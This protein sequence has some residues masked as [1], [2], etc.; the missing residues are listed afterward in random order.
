[1]AEN[2]I[3]QISEIRD[4]SFAADGLINDIKSKIQES[5]VKGLQAEE[6]KKLL[7]LA[8]AAF[9]REDFLTAIQRA[10]DAQLSIV[11]E[12]KGNINI[13][14]F[15]IDYQWPILAAIIILLIGSYFIRRQ[16]ILILISRR[17]ENL[18]KEEATINELIKE[19]QEK[20][21]KEKKIGTTEYHKVMYGYEKRL[22]EISQMMSKLMSKRVG[23]I[24]ISNEIK[25]LRKE[26][27][28][29]VNL[30]KQLQEAYYNKQ[31]ITRKVYLKRI[32]EYKLRRAEIE[33]SIAVLEAKLS[34]KEKLEELK[35]N[36][37]K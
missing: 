8:L 37:A 23:I 16:L 24:K 33:K 25:N 14:K 36:D 18:Q 15:I 17:L 30:I 34:K 1:M 35:K 31:A 3:K 22:G 4:N 9:E 19:T 2:I 28:N 32:G 5:E 29:A 20:Y 12:T 10:K 21:Y 13:T 27:G 26:D 7:D 6:T 11:I